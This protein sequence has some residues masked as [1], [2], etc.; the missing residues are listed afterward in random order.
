V[1]SAGETTPPGAVA[2][3]LEL[4]R[5]KARAS[6]KATRKKDREPPPIAAALPV[7]RVAVDLPLPHLDRPFDYLVPAA[8]DA[9]AVP[10]ARVR[11]RFA[12]QAV[13]GYLLERTEVSEHTG[14]LARLVKVVSPEPVLSP[15]VLALARAVATRYAGTLADVLRLAIPPRHA[16]TEVET[17]RERGVVQPRIDTASWRNYATGEAFMGALG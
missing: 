12:G 17:P 4:V 3:Q 1:N 14:A 5:G 9:D 6:A 11:I 15:E 13:D 10:G 8:L 2:E 7:A 16:R